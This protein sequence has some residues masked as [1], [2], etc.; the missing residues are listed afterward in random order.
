[1]ACVK[2]YAAYG[3]PIAGRDY[4]TVDMS[5]RTFRDVYLPPYEAAIDEG[6]MTVMTAFNEYDGVPATA[7]KFLL[8]NLLR[9]NFGFNG[10]VVTDYTSINE[11]VNH[12]YAVD[13]AHAGELAVNAGV[14]MDMQG[15]VFMN[16]LADS[17]AAGR[18]SE[19]RI[20]EAV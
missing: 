5:E 2:H 15:A 11:M 7:N 1:M 20:D 13:D 6:A 18:V 19:A 8:Q 12:G 3:A 4:N 10:F 9:E 16:H 14:D 17:V